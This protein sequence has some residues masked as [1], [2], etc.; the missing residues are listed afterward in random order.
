MYMRWFING[1]P[2][3]AKSD[4]R[5][6]QKYRP[7]F[8]DKPKKVKLDDELVKLMDDYKEEMDALKG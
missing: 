5:Y 8:I 2:D 6:M 4:W 3:M 1:N 7:V